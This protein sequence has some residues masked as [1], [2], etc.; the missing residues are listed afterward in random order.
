MTAST[1]PTLYLDFDG[2]LHPADV[3][4]TKAEPLRPRVYVRGVAT[5]QPLFR[6]M[7]LLELL[8]A[9][10]PELK[11]VLATS[12]VA[13]LGFNFAVNRLSSALQERV[14]GATTPAPTR[15]ESI[16]RDAESRGLTRWLAL[17]DDLEGWPEERRHL[18][19]A[20]TNPVLALAQPG[21]AGE[22]S[23]MLKALCAGRPLELETKVATVL[24]TVERLWTTGLTEDEIS[25]A[26]DEDARVDEILRQARAR[27]PSP[28]VTAESIAAGEQFMAEFRQA[29]MAAVMARIASK[30]LISGAELAALWDVSPDGLGTAIESGRLFFI[31]SQTGE[32]YFAAFFAEERYARGTLGRVSQAL[33]DLPGEAKYSFFTNKSFCLGKTPLE[34]LASGR[35]RDV[36]VQARAFSER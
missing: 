32:R 36:L 30:E 21:V 16:N 31:S 3:R 1:L 34:A 35:L 4:M 25:H 9:P 11:I 24:P 6:Y 18:V 15:F 28:A 7:P 20:P 19:V 10:Y 13:T 2:I 17:D 29:S 5:D 14:I 26:L 8:L 12:W 23:Q 33:Q 22:L 27:P